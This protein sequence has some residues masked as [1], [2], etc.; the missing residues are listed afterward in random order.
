V[1]SR[2]F[3]ARPARWAKAAAVSTLLLTAA[4]QAAPAH[5]EAKSVGPA[6]AVA[7]RVMEGFSSEEGFH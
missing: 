2:E 3:R 6:S 7:L 4:I 1:R 5:A